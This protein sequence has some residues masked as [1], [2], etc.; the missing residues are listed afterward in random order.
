MCKFRHRYMYYIF[1]V[2]TLALEYI[3][4]RSRNVIV[5]IE[6]PSY[7]PSKDLRFRDADIRKY[8]IFSLPTQLYVYDTLKN[9][10]YD[11]NIIKL[12]D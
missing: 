12:F 5:I 7:H 2:K 8:I 9:R 10:D 3:E 6:T 4:I 1:K 11:Y